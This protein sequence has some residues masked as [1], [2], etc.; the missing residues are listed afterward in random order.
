MFGSSG[1]EGGVD[2]YPVAT[3]RAPPDGVM[4]FGPRSREPIDTVAF[5]G[6]QDLG[7]IDA[8]GSHRVDDLLGLRR[9]TGR[10]LRVVR[11]A[12]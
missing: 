10:G 12:Q 3:V 2:C 7:E 5:Q 9:V 8:R 4:Q 6:R 11:A 1:P